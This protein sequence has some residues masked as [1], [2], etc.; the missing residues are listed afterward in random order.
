M[1]KMHLTRNYLVLT[2]VWEETYPIVQKEERV[3]VCSFWMHYS[4]KSICLYNKYVGV[5]DLSNQV[6]F[7]RGEVCNTIQVASQVTKLLP[8]LDCLSN[9]TLIGKETMLYSIFVLFFCN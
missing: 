2:A 6:Y 7:S 4:A 9:R 5:K 1:L 3:R 8:T